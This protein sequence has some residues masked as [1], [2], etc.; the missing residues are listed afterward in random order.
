MALLTPNTVTVECNFIP[1]SQS[2]GCHVK[3]Y[4]FSMNITRNPEHNSGQMKFQVDEVL[5]AEILVFDWEEDGS[6]G[7]VSVPVEVMNSNTV[8]PPGLG[9]GIRVV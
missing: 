8:E 6:I 2:R 4:N 3:M 1:G 5:L 9:S 7:N